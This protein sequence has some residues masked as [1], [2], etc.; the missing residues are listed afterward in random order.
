MADRLDKI[1]SKVDKIDERL[2][3]I[4]IILERQVMVSVQNTD[5][6]KEHMRRTD[7]LE[8]KLE[9]VENHV[10]HITSAIKGILWFVGVMGSILVTLKKLGLI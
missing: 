7:L 9:P 8:K 4:A 1:E 3:H 6:L 2:D 5:S 10:S